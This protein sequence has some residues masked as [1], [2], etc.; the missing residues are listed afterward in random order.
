MPM[1]DNDFDIGADYDPEDKYGR[2]FRDYSIDI[3]LIENFALA[4]QGGSVDLSNYYTKS[5]AD[6]LLAQKENAA[7]L[8][9]YYIKSQVDSFLS[10]KADAT[11]LNNYIPSSSRAVAAGVAT[12]DNNTLVPIEQLPTG[13][14][15]NQ[16]S[17]G[18][19]NT[20]RVC[21]QI[22]IA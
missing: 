7:D 6:S 16:I 10:G 5:Q 3:Q 22:N 1:P 20:C 18:N 21:I 9:G 19:H 2:F 14:S 17:I 12:L 8:S 13:S 15:S 11:Q 4:G